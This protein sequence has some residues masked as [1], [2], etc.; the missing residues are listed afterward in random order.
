MCAFVCV[1]V[2]LAH[3]PSGLLW[4]RKAGG[5]GCVEVGERVPFG[6]HLTKGLEET[7]LG[8]QGGV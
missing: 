6:E 3:L 2:E 4:W 5:Q 8:R 1:F 7:G